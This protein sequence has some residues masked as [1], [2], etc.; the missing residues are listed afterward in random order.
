M[1]HG[2]NEKRVE[3]EEGMRVHLC[4]PD[5]YA[6]F[7]PSFSLMTAFLGLVKSPQ[8]A[9]HRIRARHIS[10]SYGNSGKSIFD[11]TINFLWLVLPGPI[12]GC[13]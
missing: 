5:L 12:K 2:K 7:Q 8:I 3:M 11:Q 13:L 4:A 1:V 9:I 10:L 6:F